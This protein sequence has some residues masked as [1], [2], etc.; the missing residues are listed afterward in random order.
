MDVLS[1]M[2]TAGAY[3]GLIWGI[4]FIIYTLTQCKRRRFHFLSR[5]CDRDVLEADVGQSSPLL[6]SDSNNSDNVAV[7]V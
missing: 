2:N 1:G 5:C 3:G 6:S 7:H 4:C